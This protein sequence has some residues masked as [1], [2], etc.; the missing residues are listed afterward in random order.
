MKTIAI[1]LARSNSIG[2]K[3]KN[4]KMINNKPLIYYTVNFLKKP[5]KLINIFY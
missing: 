1:I 3:N 2:L 5:Y 4:V